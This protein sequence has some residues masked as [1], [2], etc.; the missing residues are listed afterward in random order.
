MQVFHG[1]NVID[2]PQGFAGPEVPKAHLDLAATLPQ[3]FGQELVFNQLAIFR[4]KSVQNRNLHGIS[5][6]I[7]TYHPQARFVDVEGPE[8]EI[9]HADEN[10][11]VL[12]DRKEPVA[13]QTKLNNA[14]TFAWEHIS[15]YSSRLLLLLYAEGNQMTSCLTSLP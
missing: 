11:Q 2:H 9:A 15:H 8:L 1:E 6:A 7:Q 12:E 4:K 14:P 5:Q 3:H 10:V 13:F